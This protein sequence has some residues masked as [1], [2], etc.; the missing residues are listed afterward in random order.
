MDDLTKDFLVESYENLDRMDRDFVELEKNPSKEVLSS[1]FRAIHTIK[2][3]CGFLAYTKLERVAHA[4]ENLLSLLRDGALAVNQPI[5]DALLAMV[6]AV[7]EILR[8]IETSGS[9]G[10][11]DD[12]ALIETLNALQKG[13]L[14]ASTVRPID[15]KVESSAPSTPPAKTVRAPEPVKPSLEDID[16][17]LE[18]QA[19]GDTRLLGEI[20]VQEGHAGAEEIDR[21]LKQQAKGDPRRL[22][23]ILLQPSNASPGNIADPVQT[24]SEAKSA[25]S[26][27]TIRVDVGIL[28]KLMNLVGELVLS[29]NQIMQFAA[30]QEDSTFLATSQHLNLVTSEL[31]EGVM[32]TRMQPIGN[33]WSKFPRIVRDLAASCKKQVRVEMEGA[34]TELDRTIIEA[35]KDPL[36]HVVRNSVDHGIESPEARLAAG[37]VAEGKLLLRAY[38]EGGQVNIEIIDDGAGINPE[39]IRDKALQKGLIT[40]EQA[41]RMGER[42]MVNLVFLAGLST[43]EKV[44][45]VSGRGVG[46]D[47]VKTN[48]EKIGGTVDVQSKPGQGTALK[49]KI[50]LT[51]AII[52]ALMVTSG[53]DR[54]AIPQVSL[55]ELVRLDGEQARKGVEMVHG[56]PVY[57]LRGNLLPLLYLN[58]IL[59]LPEVNKEV[60][61]SVNIVVLQADGR[62]F[63]LV[64]NAINDSKDIVVKPLG[65]HLKGL[66]AFSGATILGDG[67]V[68]LILDVIGISQSAN[69]VAEGRERPRLDAAALAQKSSGERQSL[70]ICRYGEGGRVAIPLSLVARLEEFPISAMEKS[71]GHEV[72]QYRGEIMPLI[73]LAQVLGE[74]VG[75]SANKENVQVVVYRDHG[76]SVGLVVE[77][78]ADIIEEHVRVKSDGQTGYFTGSA[79]VQG[80]VTDI[81]NVRG[82][83]ESVD[84]SYLS[85]PEAA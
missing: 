48:I 4:G 33:V 66:A 64:V 39:K 38:H 25:V 68:A 19:K 8:S 1:I 18:Q 45:N 74:D 58:R 3:T 46:M 78:I 53:G 42:E 27:S 77:Q 30:G 54:Y 13:E 41:G 32:K 75:Q 61:A 82:V 57:R 72:T 17:A 52:P 10:E 44:T 71:S 28:D 23:D 65:K 36:T 85:R 80:K 81:L 2:G 34:E 40:P 31:Q 16:R 84:P 69:F 12:S 49:V 6:D 59:N 73:R 83:I 43:A 21:A 35:I 62:N 56:A 55:T 47:V 70:L 26:D 22:G 67:A 37:K 7:R 29:R 5:T 11:R 63:G 51:L 24:Q 20:L 76:R 15:A 9:E 79:V 14:P 50:P 60:D